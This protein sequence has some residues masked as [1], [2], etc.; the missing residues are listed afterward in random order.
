MKLFFPLPKFLFFWLECF[1]PY[2][3]LIS[4]KQL[5]TIS[6]RSAP[7][8]IDWLTNF[9]R[10]AT[11]NGLTLIRLSFLRVVFS[12]GRQFDSLPLPLY[13]N[14][15]LSNIIKTLYDC[16][17]GYLKYVESEKMLTSS[18]TSWRHQFLC[19]KVMSKNPKNRWKL[20]QSSWYWQS[21][22]VYILND[23]R[24]INENFRKDVS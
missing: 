5:I 14:K 24:K 17:T 19:Y 11:W 6:I 13:F 21:I 4:L 23:L 18:I 22:S 9:W 15:N 10:W 7:F 20:M 3:Y 12:G 16:W 2:F 1:S 8:N